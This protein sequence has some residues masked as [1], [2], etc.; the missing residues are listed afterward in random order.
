MIH[1]GILDHQE[2]SE[3]EQL[4]GL[5]DLESTE[6]SLAYYLSSGKRASLVLK[7]D[8]GPSTKLK[9]AAIVEEIFIW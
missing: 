7:V 6:G 8:Q 1:E 4:L 9:Q 2:K 3:L 5:P